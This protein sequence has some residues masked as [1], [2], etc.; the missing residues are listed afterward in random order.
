MILQLFSCSEKM[1][2]AINNLNNITYEGGRIVKMEVDYSSACDETIP[3]C[4]E[5]AKNESHFNEALEML[6]QLEKQT[7][8]VSND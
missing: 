1:D 7:R 8:I 2:T 4:K 3:K 5:M 6:L